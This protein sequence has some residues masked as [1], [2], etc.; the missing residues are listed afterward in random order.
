MRKK[1]GFTLAE[2]SV[3]MLVMSIF[4]VTTF[5]VF[6]QAR[7]TSDSD[8]NPELV[9]CLKELKENN[10]GISFDAT[11]K[12]SQIATDNCKTAVNGCAAIGGNNCKLAITNADS[13][14]AAESIAGRKFLRAACDNNGADA[15]EYFLGK[16]KLNS[17]DPACNDTTSLTDVKFADLHYYLVDAFKIIADPYQVDKD[18]P[19]SERLLY[20]INSKYYYTTNTSSN[21]IDSMNKFCKDEQN[22]KIPGMACKLIYDTCNT[23]S[24]TR[25]A[26][27]A[28]VDNCYDN[29]SVCDIKGYSATF[30]NYNSYDFRSLMEM[31]YNAGF[32]SGDIHTYLSTATASG[33]KN[34]FYTDATP[35]A[36]VGPFVNSLIEY[37][38]TPE[39]NTG[40]KDKNKACRV[41]ND[42]CNNFVNSAACNY[43]VDK[44]SQ[45]YVPGGANRCNVND[46]DDDFYKFIGINTGST[47]SDY[48]NTRTK[49]YMDDV[50]NASL[51]STA[52][53]LCNGNVNAT[54]CKSM[55]E[56][57]NADGSTQPCKY[58]IDIC[59]STP[60]RC[61][62]NSTSYTMDLKYYLEQP[63]SDT[64]A[65]GKVKKLIISNGYYGNVA[66]ITSLIDTVCPGPGDNGT[67]AC[68]AKIKDWL[69][70]IGGGNDD[71]GWRMTL[72]NDSLYLSGRENSSRQGGDWDSFIL[73]MDLN[74]NTQW[75]K[76]YGYGNTDY[77]YNTRIFNGNIYFA[78]YVY[79]SGSGWY[80][81]NLFKL[82]MDGN[83]VWK[84]YLTYYYS[85]TYGLDVAGGNIFVHGLVPI[86][87]DDMFIAKFNTDGV[88]AWYKTSNGTGNEQARRMYNDGTYLYVVVYE[89]VTTGGAWWQPS[90]VKMDFEGNVIWAKA[91]NY[92]PNHGYSTDLAI[93]GENLYMGGFLEV[94]PAGGRDM[95]ITKMDKNGNIIWNKVI[96]GTGTDYINGLTTDGTNVFLLGAETTTSYGSYDASIIKMSP[97]GDIVWQKRVG[98]SSD[99]YFQD[100]VYKDG[101]IYAIGESGYWNDIIVA[102]FNDQQ[103]SNMNLSIMDN[104][105][106]YISWNDKFSMVQRTNVVSTLAGDYMENTSFT[107]DV[108]LPI[109]Q[110]WP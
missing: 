109:Y 9:F 23:V 100:G 67:M 88:L 11:G 46:V 85:H 15:C 7:K 27:K 107:N 106:S 49:P 30:N 17:T 28:I 72:D 6:T 35:G 10:A 70:R 71:D 40:Y 47:L 99:D 39:T 76:R 21:F 56:K 89:S 92:P 110:K 81:P 44:C 4:L 87:A 68:K 61:D 13:A 50:N 16:C 36:N 75:K 66:S 104:P 33:G 60:S 41:T 14:D 101:N 38:D 63:D 54:G 59:Q 102:K 98:S 69:K 95:F 53:T 25:H 108:A 90:L 78:N 58:F 94:G 51:V 43:M 96:G 55:F 18:N 8:S 91:M 45:S 64:G 22:A 20:L 31:R 2:M 52:A 32:G 73:K 74:G 97:D 3:V 29:N 84:K 24:P 1:S 93:V 65:V 12:L 57:C 5:S 86:N 19:G 103:V 80:W 37:C 83:L 79:H 105:Y 42:Y 77:G 62:Y 26:C 82:D 34:Y 48:I